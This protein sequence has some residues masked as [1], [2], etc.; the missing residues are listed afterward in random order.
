MRQF[1][2]QECARLL[3]HRSTSLHPGRLP[4]PWRAGVDGVRRL[5]GDRV[6]GEVERGAGRRVRSA[7]L[8]LVGLRE[9]RLRGAG[10]DLHPGRGQGR[11]RLCVG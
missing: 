8:V 9:K 3:S 4:L 10:H 2:Q 6:V 5:A 7:V 1:S 11:D